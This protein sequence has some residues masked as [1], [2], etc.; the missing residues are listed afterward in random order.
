VDDLVERVHASVSAAG[1]DD[2]RLVIEL[3]VLASVRAST[4]TTVVNSG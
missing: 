3:K 1:A 4:P 2:H